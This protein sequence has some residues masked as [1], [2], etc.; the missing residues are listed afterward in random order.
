[1]E[2]KYWIGSSADVAEGVYFDAP[3][4]CSDAG[5]TS[6][7]YFCGFSGSMI[8]SSLMTGDGNEYVVAGEN[9]GVSAK[10]AMQYYP[11][12]R[13]L[14]TS[15]TTVTIAQTVINNLVLGGL[16]ANSKNVLALYNTSN[17]TET[18]LIGPDNEIEVYHANYVAS[19]NKIMFDRLR[20]A[21]N[22]YVIGEVN[23]ST[24][25]VTVVNAGSTKWTD[26]QAFS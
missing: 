7:N 20:F 14:S 19:G 1:M 8:V 22:K 3:T 17:D 16:N 24:H 18:Q 9:G 5:M 13:F 26:L 10:Y 2:S 12:V 4:I 11:T 21:D 23:L 25:G 15:L 6:S